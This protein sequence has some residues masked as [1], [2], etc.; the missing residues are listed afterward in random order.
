MKSN[1]LFILFIFSIN[2]NAAVSPFVPEKI[3]LNKKSG[4]STFL[5][6]GY[7]SA[8]HIEGKGD[9]PQGEITIN[10]KNNKYYISG[11]V[12]VDLSSYATGIKMRD[13]HMKEKYLEVSKYNSA[14]LKLDSVEIDIQ[15]LNKKNADIKSKHQIQA[16][17]SLHGQNKLIPIELEFVRSNKGLVIKSQ[18]KI[19]LTDFNIQIPQFAGIKVAETVE[20]K[21]V[22]EFNQL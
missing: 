14:I 8:M 15:F 21:T 12:E 3:N 22:N 6:M 19:T 16:E 7:P 4:Y 13:Q 2:L 1:L 10:E 18:F 20:I 17:L 11:N 5:A 9:A